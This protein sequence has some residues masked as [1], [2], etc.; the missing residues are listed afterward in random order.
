[1][2]KQR[3]KSASKSMLKDAYNTTFHTLRKWLHPFK[4]QIGEYRG[5]AYTPKQVQIIIECIGEPENLDLIV[6]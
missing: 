5:Q 1:M 2:N 6:V 3:Y 4:E